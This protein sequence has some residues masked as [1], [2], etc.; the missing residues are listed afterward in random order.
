MAICYVFQESVANG[1]KLFHLLGTIVRH[2][3]YGKDGIMNAHVRVHVLN[4]GGNLVGVYSA[5]I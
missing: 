2:L 3:K 1:K 4:F 5:E